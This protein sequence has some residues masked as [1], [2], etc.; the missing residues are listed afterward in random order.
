LRR[1]AGA[2]RSGRAYAFGSLSP[3]LPGEW[4]EVARVIRRFPTGAS[5]PLAVL[6]EVHFGRWVVID[7]LKT[8]WAGV[9]RD[10]PQLNSQYVLFDVDL[11][12]P[13]YDDYELPRAFLRELLYAIPAV[14]DAVWSHCY[15]FPKS[16]RLDDVIEYLVRTQIDTTLYY[17]GHPGVSVREIRRALDQR[18]ALIEFVTAEQSTR[19]MPTLQSRYL[20][21][22]EQWFAST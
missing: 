10:T 11:T 12:V 5:S 19:V 2:N 6:P 9:P 20:T 1:R 3:I 7:E 14:V 16:G 17:V 13:D 21:A 18:D 15:G 4:P 8:D 22:A